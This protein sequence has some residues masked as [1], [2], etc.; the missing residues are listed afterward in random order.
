MY[1]YQRVL[2]VALVTIPPNFSTSIIERKEDSTGGQWEDFEPIGKR[3]YNNMF[4]YA[5]F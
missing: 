4:F 1:I 5:P 3:V 2:I